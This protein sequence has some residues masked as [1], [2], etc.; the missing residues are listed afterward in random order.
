[1][2]KSGASESRTR[3]RKGHRD[4]G[5]SQSVTRRRDLL[6]SWAGNHR[7]VAVDSLSRLMTNFTS[8]LMTWMV[9]GIAVAMPTWMYVLLNNAGAVSQD[10][11]GHPRVIVYLKSD[12]SFGKAVELSEQLLNLQEVIGA[13]YIS[14]SDALEEFKTL[15]GFGEVVDSLE[16]NPLPGAIMINPASDDVAEVENLVQKLKKY[17]PVE[18]ISVDLQWLQRLHSILQLAR[19][20]ILVVSVVLALAVALI[21]GNTIRLAI[22]SRRSEIEVVKLVGGTD[23][24]V[25]RPF[26]YTGFWFGL[27]GGLVAWLLVEA[28]LMWVS[29]PVA[30]LAGLYNSDFTLLGLGAKVGVLLFIISAG[31]GLTGAWLAVNRHL[32]VIQ[33]N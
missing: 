14:P 12:V 33:P 3:T 23:A 8:S 4:S 9:I 28:S 22:E 31:L 6:Q 13:E 11:D 19:R 24:F 5:A 21:I 32:N 10:W 25:R 2:M 30:E 1:M 17:P 7:A 27:G 26:L 18:S 15:S 29:A 16:E 20:S